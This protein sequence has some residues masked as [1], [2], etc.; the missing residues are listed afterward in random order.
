MRPWLSRKRIFDT[1][2]SGKSSRRR[3]IT[4]PML[5]A[6]VSG[7]PVGDNKVESPHHYLVARTELC[8]INPLII[9]VSAVRR[10][11]VFDAD[12][13]IRQHETTMV[14][15]DGHVVEEDVALGVSTDGGVAGPEYVGHTGSGAALDDQGKPGE[16]VNV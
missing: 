16:T 11:A 5:S 10:P 15:R 7:I 2:T 13:F 8:P 12:L 1:D 14:S 9:Y 3:L 6:L 4:S